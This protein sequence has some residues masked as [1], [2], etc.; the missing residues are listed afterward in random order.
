MIDKLRL[1][2]APGAVVIL[3]PH[4]SGFPGLA[5]LRLQG[6]DTLFAEP[7]EAER[8]FQDGQVLSLA[9]GRPI[10]RRPAPMDGRPTVQTFGAPIHDADLRAPEPPRN[11]APFFGTVPLPGSFATIEN[12]DGR[13]GP[14]F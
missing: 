9:T 8:L 6:G 11:A 3:D 5:P 7:A 1:T 10:E 2:V 13:T 12:A 14:G 4:P